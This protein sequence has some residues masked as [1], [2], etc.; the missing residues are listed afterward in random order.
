VDIKED[1]AMSDQ[2]RERP[3]EREGEYTDT[4][5]SDVNTPEPHHGEYTESEI[6]ED[7]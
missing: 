7:E 1:P 2:K 3:E 6:P 4:E 5:A